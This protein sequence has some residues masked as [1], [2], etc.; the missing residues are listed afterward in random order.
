MSESAFRM[1]A[2]AAVL[3]GEGRVLPIAVGGKNPL[4]S[5]KNSSF[6]LA[7]EAEWAP[8]IPQ[9]VE[10]LAAQFP[11]ANVAVVAKPNEKLFIDEDASAE[12]RAG[13]ELWSGEQFPQT[14]ATS[15]RANRLQSH[16]LQTDRTRAMGN[17]MQGG[18]S[19]D[20][21]VRQHNMYVLSEGSRHKNGVDFYKSVGG[22]VIL[23]MP[24]KL[25]DYLEL[26]RV[27]AAPG[28][29][30]EIA[31]DAAGL[32]PHG[33]IHTYMLREAGRLRNLGLDEEPIY[34]ALSALVHKNC[35]PPINEE[36]IRQMAKSICSF[37]EGTTGILFNQK[38]EALPPVEL[39]PRPVQKG[40]A[41]P[42]FPDWVMAGT[43]VYENFV[44]PYCKH[45]S[46]IPY[47]MWVPAM[48]ML[49]NYIAPK[50]KIKSLVGSRAAKG[51]IYTVIIGR[52]GRT[53]KS[54]CVNDARDYFNYMGC[55]VSHSRD[56]KSAE[57]RTVAYTVGSMESLGINMQKADVKSALL[58]YDELSNLV[59]KAGIE[60]SS[61]SSHLLTCYEGNTFENGVKS[62]KESFSIQPPYCLSLIACTTDEKFADQWSKMAGKDT[63][64]DDRFTFILQPEVLPEPKVWTPVSV[65]QGS[66]ATRQLI[67]RAVNQGEF[68]FED[69]SDPKLLELVKKDNRLAMRA[70]KWALA[71]A[72]DLGRPEIDS[73]CVERAFALVQYEKQVKDYLK[74]YEAE[75][76]ESQI[77]QAVCRALELN[78]G[79]MEERDLL[80]KF[81]HG[82]KWGTGLW[83]QSY[84]GMFKSGWL[85][86]V[87][88]GKKGD[89]TTI[90]L[91]LES[92][93][94]E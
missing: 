36:K 15:A 10:T 85:R 11:D 61:L 38:P 73:D 21:S 33:D 42:V 86:R 64:M 81:N 13:F 12:F 82:K 45:N 2:Y 79:A 76:R 84:T 37:E 54:S 8:Q 55:L 46:R 14:Y 28:E 30:V 77:Q 87:G 90:E 71:L 50:V 25:V 32:I 44:A 9:W 75:T 88:T 67:D 80:R 60:Q 5:W 31:R 20:I 94:E 69:L 57:G 49:L 39:E 51:A 89:P 65:V 66:L 19:A 78:K 62:T 18:T 23:P 58:V 16:W 41:Y 93:S 22:P 68:A 40:A 92:P 83:S 3:R 56:L 7:S 91:M 29:K 53:V 47:F 72:V 70:E 1:L 27:K 24:D 4:I 35:A 6:D 74:A 52:Y 17:I 59:G 63:G 26:I 34:T 48:T 43:S